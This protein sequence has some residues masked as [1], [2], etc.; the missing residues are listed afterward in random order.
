[1]G[2]AA[3]ADSEAKSLFNYIESILETSSVVVTGKT[4][5]EVIEDMIVE[6]ED[7][8]FEDLGA[9]APS[10]DMVV[11]TVNN[12]VAS[13]L[14]KLNLA[15]CDANMVSRDALSNDYDVKALAKLPKKVNPKDIE[16]MVYVPNFVFARTMCEMG[17]T[18]TTINQTGYKPNTNRW[19]AFE[20]YG[21]DLLHY[22][23]DLETANPKVKPVFVGVKLSIS[24]PTPTP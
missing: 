9:L 17:L 3:W 23:K 1:M 4:Y 16:I 15:C 8:L 2:T 21:Y 11:V 12:K 18:Q 13:E 10:R 20:D 22:P 19:F 5:K 14:K 7:K 6:V 24:A